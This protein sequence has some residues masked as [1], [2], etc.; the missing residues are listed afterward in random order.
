MSIV[1]RCDDSD[2]MMMWTSRSQFGSLPTVSH[3][4]LNKNT[5]TRDGGV[6][7]HQEGGVL[8]EGFL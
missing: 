4:L 5:G 1:H 8:L 2:G 6:K 3:L 7:W